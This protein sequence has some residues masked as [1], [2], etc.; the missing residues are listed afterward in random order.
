MEKPRVNIQPIS[1]DFTACLNYT[2][3]CILIHSIFWEHLP[4]VDRKK[5][6]FTWTRTWLGQCHGSGM[7]SSA[8]YRKGQDSIPG[9]SVWDLWQTK[10]QCDR[11]SF[12]V[13]RFYRVGIIPL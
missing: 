5:P 6:Q 12:R 9:Q 4:L 11:F 10:W 13:L 8:T 7:S 3:L 2:H 1:A